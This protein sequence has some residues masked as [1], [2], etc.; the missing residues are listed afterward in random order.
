MSGGALSDVRVLDLCGPFGAFGA[1]MLADLGADVVKVEP[2]GG[3]VMRRRGPFAPGAADLEASL[4]FFLNNANKRGIVLD[5]EAQKGQAAFTRLARAAD[6]VMESTP[7][8]RMSER[9]IGYEALSKA[10]PGLVWVAIAPFGQDGPF[11]DFRLSELSAQAIG[12]ALYL[13]GEKHERPVMAGGHVAEK[14]AG[15]LAALAAVTALYWRDSSG[16]GQFIDLS[17]QEAVV[18][19]MESFTTKVFY[20]GEVYSRDGR[21]YPRTYPAGLFPCTDG[22]VSL[23]A[24]PRHQW[25]ALREWVAD[26]RLMDPSF[27]DLAERM[28][29]RPYLDDILCAWTRPQAKQALFEEGQRRRIPV[30]VSFGPDET[31]VNEHLRAREYVTLL[32]HARLG[33]VEVP[34]RPYLLSGTPWALR[35]PAPLLGEHTAEVLAEAGVGEAE[36]VR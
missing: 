17:T 21:L 33:E 4:P 23:V 32:T 6:V 20:S 27:E 31:A 18:S 13:T 11:R 10:N 9:G 7:P 29:R 3:D 22:W 25:L 34:G 35:R 2:P 1:K 26:A 16:R 19:Q 28:R 12:G 36:D 14:M 24:G 15:Y 5:L 8:G 30:G